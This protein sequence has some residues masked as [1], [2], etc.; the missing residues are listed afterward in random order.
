MCLH[1][2][3][4]SH[5]WLKFKVADICTCAMLQSYTK[6][7]DVFSFGVVIWELVTL[8]VPWRTAMGQPS[9]ADTSDGSDTEDSYTRHNFFHVISQVGAPPRQLLRSFLQHLVHC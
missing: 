5:I 1:S 9:G 4:P 6:A 8:E 3:R 7:A 2:W